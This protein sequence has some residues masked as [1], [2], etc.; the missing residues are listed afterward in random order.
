MKYVRKEYSL[1]I[2]IK[3][4][5]RFWYTSKTI[6]IRYKQ[7]CLSEVMEFVAN[8]K[9]DT[10][11]ITSRAIKFIVEH[12]H[13]K[14]SKRCSE[15]D[16]MYAIMGWALDKI[17]K[18][19]FHWVFSENNKTVDVKRSPES[20][21]IVALAE[22][23][24]IDPHTMIN[25]YTSEMID[26]YSEGVIRNLNEQSKKGQSRNQKIKAE[27]GISDAD[28]KELDSLFDQLDKKTTYKKS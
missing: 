6:N 5:I 26:Y 21:G 23:L 19:Y 18:T 22:R 4:K 25:E 7:A 9:S 12:S 1:D 2:K 20:S 13:K 10:V 3:N 16:A 11:S 8:T 17:Y 28:K 14:E 24:N 27:K 15:S